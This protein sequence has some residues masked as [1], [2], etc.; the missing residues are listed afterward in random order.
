MLT[1]SL[2]IIQDYPNTHLQTASE[3]SPFGLSTPEKNHPNIKI[4]YIF[5]YVN[6]L[7]HQYY[8]TLAHYRQ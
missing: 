2:L 1:L 5:Q 3:F 8:Y 4:F 6:F 7:K